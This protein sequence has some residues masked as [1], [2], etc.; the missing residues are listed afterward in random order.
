[1][2]LRFK[3]HKTTD[4]VNCLS[5]GKCWLSLYSQ[6]DSKFKK[7]ISVILLVRLRLTAITE[8]RDGKAGQVFLVSLFTHNILL[9]SQLVFNWSAVTHL[10]FRRSHWIYRK[11]L[12]KQIMLP[13]ESVLASIF[14][15]VSGNFTQLPV[16]I[17]RWLMSFI[18]EWLQGC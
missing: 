17:A 15:C 5:R 11:D 10:V 14:C 7:N 6:L 2:F 13:F 8:Q 1:M 12:Y 9:H 3:F 4:N 16:F 18:C